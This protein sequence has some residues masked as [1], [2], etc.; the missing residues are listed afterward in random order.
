MADSPD[1]KNYIDLTIYDED[2]VEIL[3]QILATGRGL[4]PNWVPAA[5]QIEVVLAEAIATRSSELA[6]AINRLP[7]ATAEVL[8]QLFGLTRSDGVRASATLDLTFSGPTTL[9]AG[10]EFLY[11]DA[12][13]TVAYTF[14]LASTLVVTSSNL[15]PTGISVN[16]ANVGSAYNISVTGSYL[17]L[18][19]GNS[20]F[21]SAAFATDPTGGINAESD[22]QFFDRGV[23]LLASYT[24]ASTTAS[25]IKYYVSANKTY[26]NRVEVYDRRRYRDRDTTAANYGYHD[27]SILVAVGSTVSTAASASVQLPVSASNLS[28]LYS[29]L[30]TRT[31]AGLHID[32]MSAELVDIDVNVSLVKKTGAVAGT[33]ETAVKNA[34]KTYLSPNTWLWEN[35]TVR[36]NEIIALIDA[37]DGVDYV[38][39]LTLDGT[40][41]IGSNNVGYYTTS[42]GTKATTTLD[43]TGATPGTYTA[44]NAAFYY[45]DSSTDP[46]NPAV[47]TFV[48]TG[49]VTIS[50]GGTATAQAYEAVLTGAA[51]NDSNQSGGV[52]PAASMTTS[53]F[54]TGSAGDTGGTAG[55]TSG[56]EISGG[57]TASNRFTTLNGS[58][59]VT[60]DIVLRNLGTL[61]NYGTLTVTVS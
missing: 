5:G 11:V 28:D 21:V 44:G 55:V 1:V 56:N 49:T 3:N 29:S 54:F 35:Q 36:R 26:A 41:V 30:D 27:G 15:S 40:P 16:A 24:T 59:A 32:V 60:A 25:Q 50:G 34:I 42:G 6:A 58:G 4:L 17:T 23:N 13:S 8:F 7:S 22:A 9:A 43:I 38:T 57:S 33:V 47:Y 12:T 2:P 14:K 19:Q 53:T 52:I 39:S 20:Q 10:S 37:V 51:Y 18:L 46:D 48:N 31:P 61:V 45:V